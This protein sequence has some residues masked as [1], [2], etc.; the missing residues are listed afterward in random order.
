LPCLH[1]V[2]R[3]R[4]HRWPISTEAIV[5]KGQ[6]KSNREV[7][8]PKK[9]AGAKKGAAATVQSTFAQPAGKSSG[10]KK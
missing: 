8:K 2:R 9:D 3:Q 7:R 4:Q 6:Q 10:K 1:V 5:A